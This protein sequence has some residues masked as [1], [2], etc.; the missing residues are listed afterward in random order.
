MTERKKQRLL[1]EIQ[2]MDQDGLQAYIAEQ[3]DE[4]GLDLD[5]DEIDGAEIQT[6]LD[7]IADH[8]HPE[9]V[10]ELH[11]EC[12]DGDFSSMHP[13]ET[14]EEFHDHEDR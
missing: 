14:S 7:F 3:N 6:L 2:D 4:I 10:G 11:S 8:I 13:D 12:Q 1:E 5:L 9:L